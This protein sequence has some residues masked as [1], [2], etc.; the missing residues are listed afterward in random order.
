M[1][2]RSCDQILVSLS[3]LIPY[4]RT[5][6]VG[7]I[8]TR[9]S[10]EKGADLFI[11][12]SDIK[13][14]DLR[15]TTCINSNMAPSFE[16][17]LSPV[18]LI[19]WLSDQKIIAT[20]KRHKK[21]PKEIKFVAS[22]GGFILDLKDDLPETDEKLIIHT[23]ANHYDL[24]PIRNFSKDKEKELVS[25]PVMGQLDKVWRD[26][27]TIHLSKNRK[28]LSAAPPGLPLKMTTNLFGS[29][30]YIEWEDFLEKTPE[31]IDLQRQSLISMLMS[32]QK[33]ATKD[34][35]FHIKNFDIKE[36]CQ[37]IIIRQAFINH[38]ITVTHKE[39]KKTWPKRY[40]NFL[41]C[42]GASMLSEEK[43]EQLSETFLGSKENWEDMAKLLNKPTRILAGMDRF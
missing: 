12:F 23:H 42:I 25:I 10:L 43:G 31:G 29:G 8:M 33:K 14:V 9:I 3:L 30:D 41:E 36:A 24:D 34:L 7:L 20:L 15:I 40:K 38:T 32:R 35:C 17:D 1:L 16:K 11:K 26:G 22:S 4:C 18:I 21:T 37:L 28:I 6:F 27:W 19:N 2:F 13:K 39:A 5:N